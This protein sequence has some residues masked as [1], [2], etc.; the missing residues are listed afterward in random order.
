VAG[1]VPA[2]EVYA[3][4]YAEHARKAS[5]NFIGGDPHDGPMPMD[6]FVWLVRGPSGS[7]LVDTG[8]NGQAA[9]ARG[10]MLVRTVVEGLA[11]LG[12][13]PAS[14]SNVILTHMH[15]DHAGNC[16]QFP[17]ATLHLQDREM[18][19]ATGRYMAHRCMH[20]A[21]SVFD[22]LRVV[23]Y[24]YEGRVRFHAGDAELAPGLSLHLIGGHTM[25]LQ[26]VRVHTQRG[27]IVL[28][29]DAS[30]YY[31]NIEER[32]PFP[33]VF[34]V[35]QMVEGWS[36]MQELADSPDHVVPGH[37]PEV[38]RRYPAPAAELHGAV[39]ALHLPAR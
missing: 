30:H 25:G 34:N 17:A 15:Y 23:E 14:I 5:A 33:V 18:Q 3:I 26:A 8:F 22:V 38:L 13:S 20:E 10:R 35:G 36:R 4:K 24:V 9:E 11:L 16:D 19:Y 2:Y 28:A 21:Y 12:E 7:W 37:D 39:A 1:T 32:R 29:S 31:R 6:Y 27:W